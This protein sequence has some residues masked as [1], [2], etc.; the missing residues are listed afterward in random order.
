MGEEVEGGMCQ[1]GEQQRDD[2]GALGFSS[3]AGGICGN[4]RGGLGF[5]R[6]AVSAP[7]GIVSGA[8]RMRGSPGALVSAIC[9]FVGTL[10]VVERSFGQFPADF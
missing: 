4:V 7:C 1:K 3:V 6:S 10:G 2:D 9:C 5:V 8:L